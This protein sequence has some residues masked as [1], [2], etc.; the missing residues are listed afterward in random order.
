M[1][2]ENK[3]KNVAAALKKML[4][5]EGINLT[6]K[7]VSEKIE[8]EDF[9][10][11]DSLKD[12]LANDMRTTME[13]SGSNRKKVLADFLS[14]NWDII[15]DNDVVKSA[16]LHSYSMGRY[17]KAQKEEMVKELLDKIEGNVETP[18]I[19]EEDSENVDK[20]YTF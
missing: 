3:K 14:T 6:I 10:S 8:G 4:E 20:E 7:Q 15:K 2:E 19:N 16:L 9:S 13:S 11:L 5:N 17:K 18:S 12:K 1:T